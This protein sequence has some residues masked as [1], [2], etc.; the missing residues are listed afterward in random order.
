M[1]ASKYRH[2]FGQAAKKELC[3]ENL[4][5]TKNAWDSNIVNANGKYLAVTWDASGGGAFA[6]IPVDEVGKAPDKVPLFRGHKGPVLDTAFDPFNKQ[7]IA[8]C[9]DDGNILIWDIPEDFSF[10][11]Y[12]DA[13][14]N[15]KDITEPVKILKGHSRK[16][17]HVGFHP[18]AADVLAS[19]S[20]DYTVKIW[21]VETGVAE[22][23]LQHT[24]LVTSFAFN[25]NGSLMATTSRD[26]KLR[27]WDLRSGKVVSEG[28]G[29]TGAKAS[30]VVWLGNTDRICTTGFSRLSDRQ[31]G[32]WDVNDIAKGPIDGFMV[33]DSSSGIL[34]PLFDE[35]NS[36]LYLA[37]KGDGNIRY[38][39]YDCDVL[40]DL[41]QY[42]STDAQRGFAAA[43]K[44]Y[45]N[46]K[47]NEILKAYKT[48]NDN[49]IEPI[50]FIVPRKSELFQPDIYP[51]APSEKPALSASEWFGGKDVNGPLLVKLEA[52]FDGLT[53]EV[54]ESSPGVSISEKKNEMSSAKA[55]VASQ[56]STPKPAK[57][58]SPSPAP[59][60]TPETV[61]DVLKSSGQ[62][63]SLL[64]KV[65]DESDDEDSKRIEQSK[66]QDDEWEEVKKPQE[67]PKAVS[68][69]LAKEPETKVKEISS[70]KSVEPAPL[71]AE[72]KDSSEPVPASEPVVKE[73]APSSS[74][75]SSTPAETEKTPQ[76]D[77]KQ[78]QPT[79]RG[80]VDKL[81]GL[82]EKLE[83]QVA[84]LTE[85][86]VE[87]NDKI[88][89]LEAKID[90]L[91]KQ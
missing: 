53:P 86:N 17:G 52:I 28:P 57:V 72:V 31:V 24:D 33:V 56:P 11:N 6:V 9:S 7:R 79:L 87:K 40:H 60:K 13:D 58:R 66:D 69:K 25:Y 68:P 67:E 65:A 37:G 26:K 18:C 47:E 90:Q 30:R 16:V 22:I 63:D 38:F 32:I 71:E 12:K 78:A 46:L 76:P 81:A 83:A 2:V 89:S 85:A 70:P 75:K 20:M 8:S 39:E 48:V 15:V 84:K 4:K 64:T 80:T 82:V 59:E 45:V 42:A 88:E 55:K 61:D 10:R 36:I 73:Q 50:S 77:S 29:H 54:Q 34:I 49:S 51:D 27:I 62:V 21:N 14:D 44:T 3:Y 19:S 74:M 91:L 35:A 41:S 43:P 1:R 23:T 5:V